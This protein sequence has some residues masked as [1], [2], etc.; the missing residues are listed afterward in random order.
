ML[1]PL[2]RPGC[3]LRLRPLRRCAAG[4]RTLPISCA[5]FFVDM[6]TRPCSAR[7]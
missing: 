5:S 4:N 2:T 6:D 7:S 3:R 1:V